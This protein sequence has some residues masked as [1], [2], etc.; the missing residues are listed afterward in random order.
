[1]KKRLNAAGHRLV[2]PVVA[3][4]FLSAGC[5]QPPRA[6]APGAGELLFNA[7]GGADWRNHVQVVPDPAG[8]PGQALLGERESANRC[9]MT[10]TREKGFFVVPENLRG[11]V[12]LRLLVQGEGE[13]KT[14]VVAGAKLKSYYRSLPETNRWCDLVLP[15][16]GAAGKLAP[17][18]RV[19]D[20][21]LWLNPVAGKTI[22]PKESKFYLERAT[23]RPAP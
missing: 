7:A 3:G 10:F 21:T 11:A 8:G 2:A 13:V 9:Q 18:D 6:A 19:N 16:S 20:I 17:G 14:A 1:M 23:F 22:L 5:A 15:L 4:L 12:V